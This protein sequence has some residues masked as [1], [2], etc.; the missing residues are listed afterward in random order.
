MIDSEV[1]Q[2]AQY[3]AFFVLGAVV[4]LINSIAGG[5][6][7]LSLPIMI[8]L[9]M[10]A[11][12]ANGNQVSWNYDN[13]FYSTMNDRCRHRVGQKLPNAWGLYDMHGNV[14]EIC[15]DRHP[16]ASS[17]IYWTNDANFNAGSE[18]VVDPVGPST[19]STLAMRGGSCYQGVEHCRSAFR[20]YVSS[21]NDISA[22][23]GEVAHG[24]R[25]V[26]PIPMAME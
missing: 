5:G 13:S 7:T 20:Y 25:L 15:L 2:Y 23:V 8:F 26:C 1:W 17:A 21:Q 22:H 14:W 12:V 19:G 9:G 18:V 11:T 4:S 24:Y 3:P 10:P 6:S 16:G